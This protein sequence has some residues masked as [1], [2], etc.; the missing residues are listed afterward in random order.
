MFF[1]STISFSF[2]CPS[3]FCLSLYWQKN[4][5]GVRSVL[6][7]PAGMPLKSANKS[8]GCC[9]FPSLT[10]RGN[11]SSTQMPQ[12]PK[13]TNPGLWETGV[14]CV[15]Q[16]N[17]ETSRIRPS[18]RQRELA[19]QHPWP[20]PGARHGHQRPERRTPERLCSKRAWPVRSTSAWPGHSR[21]AWPGHSRSA[22]VHRSTWPAC[23]TSLFLA[24]S[25]PSQTR[26]C[27]VQP[28][29]PRRQPIPTAYDSW[30][31]LLNGLKNLGP[32]TQLT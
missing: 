3:S 18:F 28:P 32:D 20:E 26:P 9:F 1:L 6:S 30:F 17:F 23:S 13:K 24:C 29:P 12:C 21:S 7:A 10:L 27:S 14:C 25:N 19:E 22:S 15:Q 4:G 5:Y 11:R 31:I 8:S 16:A 2:F